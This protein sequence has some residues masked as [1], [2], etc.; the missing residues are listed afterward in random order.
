VAFAA[1][2]QYRYTRELRKYG[3]LFNADE[4]PCPDRPACADE[5]GPLEFFG[6]NT[7]RD[8]D[9][10]VKAI[11]A[12]VQIPVLDNF[13][14]NAAIRYEDYQGNIG[15]STNPKIAAKWQITDWFA[16][17][18]S[19]STTFRAPGVGATTTACNNGV[20]ILGASYRA[21]QACGNPALKPEK[22]DTFNIGGLF[23]YNGFTATLDY[24]NFRFKDEIIEESA[25]RLFA[26]MFPGGLATNCGNPAFAALEARFTF[27]GA[28]GAG[29]IARLRSFVING[30]RTDTSG[31]EFRAQYDWDGWFDGHWAVGA[32][33]TYLIEYKRKGVNL[34]NST[35]AISPDE[36][37]AGQS[38][39]LNE[40]FS[41]TEVKAN[42]FASYSKDGLSFRWQTR[43]AEGTS[44][45]FGS[46]F[47]YYVPDA[48]A[49]VTAAACPTQ[50]GFACAGRVLTP[51]GKSKDYWQHDIIVRWEAPW[52]T[53]ITGSIQN[54]FDKDPPFQP[55]PYNYDISQGNPLGRVFE[56][57]VKKRF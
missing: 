45:A 33:A 16:V 13:N 43:Y 54:V 57:G 6:S 46:P 42:L 47:F 44:P 21:F 48:S 26:T 15:S 9:A 11:F 5:T 55:G 40:F 10:N 41:Y 27:A 17:R 23:E 53:V 36:D 1:G 4:N 12:E 38:D 7:D 56:V 3:A 8:D 52:D 30:P 25:S 19:A 31:L 49:T 32:E 28:C 50:T 51:V 24:F 37:R 29:N 22:A 39:G 2:V 20:R 34:L 14:I 35:I 18:G